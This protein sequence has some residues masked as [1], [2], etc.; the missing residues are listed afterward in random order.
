MDPALAANVARELPVDLL[1][2]AAAGTGQQSSEDAV[3]PLCKA[4]TVPN[5]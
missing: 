1:G 2:G 5:D 4:W 3:M